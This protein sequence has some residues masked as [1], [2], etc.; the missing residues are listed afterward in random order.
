MAALGGIIKRTIK[1]ERSILFLTTLTLA[2]NAQSQNPSLMNSLMNFNLLSNITEGYAIKCLGIENSTTSIS[3]DIK[4]GDPSIHDSEIVGSI[5]LENN[6][7]S[8]INRNSN[9]A[10]IW[11]NKEIPS[12]FTLQKNDKRNIKKYKKCPKGPIANR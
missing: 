9:K 8:C 1:I 4:V 11:Q 10:T 12:H 5:I 7:F 3:C 6:N 2:V